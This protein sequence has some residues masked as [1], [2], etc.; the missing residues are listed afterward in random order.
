[1]WKKVGQEGRKWRVM[2][3]KKRPARRLAGDR[4]LLA[5]LAN[6]RSGAQSWLLVAR[7]PWRGPPV[8]IVLPNYFILF[9]FILFFGLIRDFLAFWEN[10]CIAPLFFEVCPYT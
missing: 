4:W 10:G 5:S 3:T 8:P 6:Q 1:M 2:Y 9:Y 7:R